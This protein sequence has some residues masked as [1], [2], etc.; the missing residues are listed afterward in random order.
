[1]NNTIS[2]SKI[3][4]LILCLVITACSVY[5][6]PWQRKRAIIYDVASYYAYLPAAFIY[7]DFS[8]NFIHFLPSN[9]PYDGVWVNNYE[10]KQVIKYTMGLAYFYYPGF[11]VADLY[12]MM[13]KRYNRNGYSLP[14]QLA[15]SITALL[16]GLCSIFLL[17]YF[18]SFFFGDKVIALLLPAMVLGTN[19]LHYVIAEPGMS[20]AYSFFLVLVLSISSE[21]FK[22]TSKVKWLLTMAFV[23]GFLVLIR[24]TNLLFGFFPLWLNGRQIV[25]F[26]KRNH[27]N[28]VFL[29]GALILGVLPF[30]PQMV[31]WKE[32]TGH[33]IFYSYGDEHFFFKNPHIWKGLFGF[34]KGLFLYTPILLFSIPGLYFLGKN[35][36]Q[37]RWLFPISIVLFLAFWVLFSWWCWWY[38]G[39]FGMR[40]LIEFYPLFA[41]LM[42]ATF[43]KL[44]RYQFQK[45]L[46]IIVA[47]LVGLNLFQTWQYDKTIIHWEAMSKEAYFKVFLK[48]KFPENYQRLLRKP[49]VVCA[50]KY[51]HEN[52]ED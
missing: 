4:A 11:V 25:R 35:N 24:P 38:G 22:Q 23:L 40:A 33:W 1:M 15:L 6:K 9:E 48:T 31:Y 18:L 28:Y 2:H 44:F 19:Y 14:Y 41:L 45:P 5:T 7:K 49:N 42:G 10:D 43:Q 52:C 36:G 39:G 16:L 29:M 17:R 13:Q 37:K 32:I 8:L 27:K 34:R 51:G 20:H 26:L 47:L 30:I 46:T 3:V 50:L 12:T 21:K